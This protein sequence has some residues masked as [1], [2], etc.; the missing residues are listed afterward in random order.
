MDSIFE[1]ILLLKSALLFA[2]VHTDDLRHVAQALDEEHYFSG[3]RVFDI[4]DQGDHMYIVVS[5][6][7]GVSI[8][9]NPTRRA[10]ITTLGPGDYFGEMNLLDELPRSATVHVLEDSRFLVL[11][12]AR[13]RGLILSY[14]ELGLGMLK[15]FSLRLR[16][17]T[18]TT[19]AHG[20][21]V[22]D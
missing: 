9:A 15:S 22:R 6:R 14:P 8:D 5:G 21:L 20:D 19:H 18:K 17:T 12:K 16:G 1:R 10:F 4:G 7:V 3:D 2:E 13:L 11:E